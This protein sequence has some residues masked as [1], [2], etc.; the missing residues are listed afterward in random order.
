MRQSHSRRKLPLPSMQ[1]LHLLRLRSENDKQRKLPSQVPKV[2]RKTSITARAFY[3]FHQLPTTCHCSGFRALSDSN[4]K[5]AEIVICMQ[6][7]F[8]LGP[9]RSDEQ[10]SLRTRF[11]KTQYS[12]AMNKVRGL[13]NVTVY[14]LYSILSLVLTREA[15]ENIGRTDKAVSPTYFNT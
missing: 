14:A 12:L 8:F 5:K 13:K 3:P 2:W 9:L 7:V 6:P 4:Q 11:L 1:D 15:A 10:S